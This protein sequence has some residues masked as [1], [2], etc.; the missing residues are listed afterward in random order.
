MT[1]LTYSEAVKRADIEKHREQNRRW[2][3]KS[4]HPCAE[5]GKPVRHE[6]VFCLSCAHRGSRSSTWKGGAFVFPDGYV[7]VTMPDHPRTHANG[8]VFEH[9]LVMERHLG[10]RLTRAE[11]VHHIN[12]DRRDNRIGNLR[13]MSRGE[14]AALHLKGTR[15]EDRPRQSRVPRECLRA[16]LAYKETK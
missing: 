6:S 12:G 11:V 10:R 3:A 4:K 16:A 9:R 15:P 1:K 14:H 8:Y 13:L 2:R 7:S 5:C